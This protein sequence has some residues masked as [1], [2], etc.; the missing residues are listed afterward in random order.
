M[1]MDLGRQTATK[2]LENNK[3]FRRETKK[4]IGERNS[5]VCKIQRS[6]QVL[7]KRNGE[8]KKE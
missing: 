3:L 2:H 5:E 4:E 6:H 7:V 8:I 1:D